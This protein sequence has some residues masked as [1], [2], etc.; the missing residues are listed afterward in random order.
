MVQVHEAVQEPLVKTDM[1]ICQKCGQ[2]YEIEA[3]ASTKNTWTKNMVCKTCHAIGTMC[4][5]NANGILDAMDEDARQSFFKR[6]CARKLEN[7]ESPLRYKMV[8]A[9]IAEA[10]KT[11]K[12][13]VCT[14]GSGGQFQPLSYYKNLGYDTSVIEN[15]CEKETHPVLGDTFLLNI[16]HKDISEIHRQV[17]ELICNAE[18]QAKRRHLP[19]EDK[20]KKAKKN[21]PQ[22]APIPLTDEE[23]RIKVSLD[24]LVDLVS[25]SEDEGK[26]KRRKVVAGSAAQARKDQR[27]KEKLST[28]K[29]QL[30]HKAAAVLQPIYTR[31]QNADKNSQKIMADFGEETK[32]S[33][34]DGLVEATKIMQQVQAVMEKHVKSHEIEE[35][36]LQ[37]QTDKEVTAEARAWRALLETFNTEKK[38]VKKRLAQAG[39]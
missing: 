35:G 26:C 7:P 22:P 4:W 10:L 21:E 15:G 6:C 18:M 36:D 17:E 19:V 32:Q 3:F 37:F 33:W 34:A 8:R 38:S 9:M 20:P 39:A 11:V 1:T 23:Q 28:K 2:S 16:T 13:K 30:A 24:G 14:T 31:M 29:V 12:E 27:E 5:R 25:D